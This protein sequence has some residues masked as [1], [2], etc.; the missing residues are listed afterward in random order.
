MNTAD[1]T[2]IRSTLDGQLDKVDELI[3]SLK[4]QEAETNLTEVEEIFEQLQAML[5]TGNEIHMRIQG[6]RQIRMDS[7]AARIGDG[8]KRREAGKKEDGNIAFKCNW[9]DKGYKGICSDAAYKYNQLYGGPWCRYQ[10]GRCRSFVGLEPVPEGCCYEARALIDCKFGAG[11]DHDEHGNPIPHGERKIRSA[12]KHKIALLTTVPQGSS[13]RLIVG[14]F[15][16]DKVLD[17]PGVETFIVGDRDFTLD[18][19]LAYKIK[20]WD[21]HENPV[22]PSSVAWATGLFRY[23]SDVAV[24]GILE[25]YIRKKISIGLNTAKA[26]NLLNRFKATC[27]KWASLSH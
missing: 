18:D 1:I 3:K 11:W 8:L 20:L 5:N 2:K 21:F 16:I 13:D 22:N 15:L 25:E 27:S 26:E 19:M 4:Y 23:V 9:N 24:L 10:H 6:N 14:A 17:D 7:L 12:R